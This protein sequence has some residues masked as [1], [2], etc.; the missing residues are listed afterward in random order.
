MHPVLA[1]DAATQLRLIA[2][3]PHWRAIHLIML[4]GVGLV[5]AGIWVRA[6]LERFGTPAAL[7]AALAIVTIGEALNALNIVYMAG[8]GTHLA[9]EFNAGDTAAPVL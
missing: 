5:I 8:S 9:W 4:A 3:T 2:A 6:L 7:L 1:G